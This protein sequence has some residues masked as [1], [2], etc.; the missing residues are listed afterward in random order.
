[1]AFA[2]AICR[3]SIIDW[4]ND[5]SLY[6]SCKS[7]KWEGSS[8]QN[9]AK[10]VPAAYQA[11]SKYRLCVHENTHGIARKSSKR[12]L[13]LRLVGREPIF[14][15]PISG[16]GVDSLKKVRNPSSRKIRS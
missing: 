16:N 4:K 5:H 7:G 12:S 13:F 8:S 15:S 2:I 10:A 3:L 9:S 1:S 14:N 11:G 6:I